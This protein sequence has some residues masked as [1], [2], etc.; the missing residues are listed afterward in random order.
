[1]TFKF[2]RSESLLSNIKRISSLLTNK[3]Y[4]PETLYP[5]IQFENPEVIA[6][7]LNGVADTDLNE[8]FIDII[9]VRFAEPSNEIIMRYFNIAQAFQNAYM[10]F[11]RLIHGKGFSPRLIDEEKNK[12][13]QLISIFK[14]VYNLT[15]QVSSEVNPTMDPNLYGAENR[16]F[17]D[18]LPGPFKETIFQSICSYTPNSGIEGLIDTLNFSFQFYGE[19]EIPSVI[20]LSPKREVGFHNDY[21]RMYTGW[22]EQYST[23]KNIKDSKDIEN[24]VEQVMSINTPHTLCYIA[25]QSRVDMN[26]RNIILNRLIDM[27][28]TPS[29]KLRHYVTYLAFLLNNK[30]KE[31]RPLYAEEIVENILK[32]AKTVDGYNCIESEFLQFEAKHELSRGNFDDAEKLFKLALDHPDR[33]S[34]GSI[35]GEIA[36][37]LFALRAATQP[38]GY[39]L[40]NQLSL[41]RDMK[42]FGGFEFHMTVAW[43]WLADPLIKKENGPFPSINLL[44]KQL[45]NEYYSDLFVPY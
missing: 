45:I 19:N 42:M 41:Y 9:A 16:A 34:I 12:L 40:S 8:R 7:V 4:T 18:K 13:N 33:I 10:R 24:G 27:D 1:G 43:Y 15:Y 25:A 38:K 30:E 35:R 23:Y 11:G 31:C 32:S 28:L 2:D 22:A 37:D 44:E 20:I 5:E 14:I 21:W 26:I 6:R 3:G 29:Q 39:S 17:E 36:R